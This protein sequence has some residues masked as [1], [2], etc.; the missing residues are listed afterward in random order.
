MKKRD[1]THGVV[2]F[3]YNTKQIDYLKLAVL[4]SKYIR[5]HMPNE[6]ICLIT[7][8]GSWNWF[9]TTKSGSNAKDLFDDLVILD[10]SHKR[11]TRI[12]YD[13][14]WSKFSSDFKNSDKHKIIDYTP[15]DKT[16]L[17]DTDYIIQNGDLNYIFDSS[18]HVTLFHN[19]KDLLQQNL[20]NSQQYLNEV[21]IPMLWSTVIYFNKHVELTKIFFD[22]WAHISEN[23]AFYKFLYQFP[24]DMFRT[25]YCVSIAA[26]IMN[27]M[28][29]GPIIES[30]PGEI[31]TMQQT[32]D[33]A[34]IIDIDEWI[35][36]VNNYNEQWKDSLTNIKN[37]NVHVMNKRSLTRCYDEL[38]A[39]FDGVDK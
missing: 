7:D 23:Y 26:H 14:P 4:A 19:A 2:F 21:G 30:F 31:I 1:I 37:E 20:S 17:L 5:R 6:K 11:N 15:Y 8:T 38:I 36:L 33:I 34:K 18:A 9:I 39:L 10:I 16:L 13:S 28:N 35:Y 24:G 29:S 12:H 25:D 27:G 32:D 3:A 22:L